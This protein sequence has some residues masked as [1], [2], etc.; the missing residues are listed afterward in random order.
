MTEEFLAELTREGRYSA[1][2]LRVTT[3]WM[4]R[5]RVFFEPRSLLVLKAKDWEDWRRS[6][7]WNPGPSGKLLS[8]NTVNQAIGAVKL[9][10]RWALS[11]G[12][13]HMDPSK[14]LKMR[15]VPKAK[16][17]EIE[18]RALFSSLLGDDPLTLRDRALYGLILETGIS[19]KACADLDLKDLRTDLGAVSVGGRQRGVRS[20]GDGLIDDLER[21]LQHGRPLLAAGKGDTEA[22][23]LG[24]R[25]R[26]LGGAAIASE[27]RA[28]RRRFAKP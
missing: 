23:F 16:K 4:E 10:Y 9:F 27:L 1:A 28:Y 7:A 8:E 6:L 15:R 3:A 2:T 22:L 21:Y 5:C 25:G 13:I 12:L 20:L 19:A 11:R 17:P 24:R 26:R 18:V 14:E